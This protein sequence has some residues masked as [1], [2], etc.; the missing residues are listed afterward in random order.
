MT[1]DEGCSFIGPAATPYVAEPSSPG[2]VTSRLSDRDFK[3]PVVGSSLPALVRRGADPVMA[4]GW[5]RAERENVVPLP[6]WL[7]SVGRASRRSSQAAARR[8]F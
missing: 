7:P 4:D 2:Q 3:E 5:P 6:P 1:S 8:L